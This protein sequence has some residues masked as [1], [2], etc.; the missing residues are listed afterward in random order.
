MQ[1]AVAESLMSLQ[2]SGVTDNAPDDLRGKESCCESQQS[3]NSSW[4]IS[5]LRLALREE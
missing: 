4:K 5:H 2:T 1:K 3:G